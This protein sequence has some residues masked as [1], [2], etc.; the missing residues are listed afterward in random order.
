MP[1]NDKAIIT[2]HPPFGFMILGAGDGVA[3]R[4]AKPSNQSVGEIVQEHFVHPGGTVYAYAHASN[5]Y[6]HT[7][8]T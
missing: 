3:L 8:V 4:R 5:T 7:Y 1:N 2:H 6:T